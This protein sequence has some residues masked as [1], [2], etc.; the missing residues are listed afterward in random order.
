MEKLRY[1]KKFDLV[2]LTRDFAYYC[3]SND[4]FAAAMKDTV[5]IFLKKIVTE[6]KIYSSESYVIIFPSKGLKA[7]LNRQDFILL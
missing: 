6:N 7:K 2:K 5:G 1:I 3:P 4:K